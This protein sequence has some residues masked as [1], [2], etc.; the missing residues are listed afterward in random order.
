MER[1][2]KKTE[3]GFSLIEL[4]VA[5]GIFAVVVTITS[6]TFITSL[7]GQR[8]AIT[9]QNVADNARYAMEVIAKEIRMGEDFT[10]GVETLQFTSNMVHR[11][12]KTVRFRYD[13]GT[14]QI[15]FDDDIADGIS[16]EPI[17]ASNSAISMLRFSVS[18]TDPGSQPRVTVV[19]G[20]ASA[21]TSADVASSMILQTTVSPR[22]L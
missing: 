18:G 16:E 15:L 17:T 5:V 9:A 7:K 4:S 11:A 6:S 13:A 21:G 22:S 20:V 3:R 1:R 12:G 14:S 10:G 2:Y 19:L 8:K